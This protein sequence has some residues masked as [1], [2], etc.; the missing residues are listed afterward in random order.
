VKVIKVECKN[1]KFAFMD[2]IKALA[3]ET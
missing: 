1:D 3:K 2:K